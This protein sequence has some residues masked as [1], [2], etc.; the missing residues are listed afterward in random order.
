MG[1]T[2]SRQRVL[3]VG[4]KGVEVVEWALRLGEGQWKSALQE[5]ADPRHLVYFVDGH[6]I[7][8]TDLSRGLMPPPMS[9]K[10]RQFDCWVVGTAQMGNCLLVI[11]LRTVYVWD[12]AADTV[13]TEVDR[14]GLKG[15]V[16]AL[17]LI[18]L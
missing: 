1:G 17:K 13:Q 15:R 12:M 3:I 2:R 14:G 9:M 8:A 7:H 10:Q 5:Q 6:T 16:H 4:Q 11:T 18:Q